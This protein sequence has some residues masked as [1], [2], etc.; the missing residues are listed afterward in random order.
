MHEG[1][2]RVAHG[3]LH[4]II[5]DSL[6]LEVSRGIVP[7]LELES[8][9]LLAEVQGVESREERHLEVH[10]QQIVEILLVRGGERVHREVAARPRVHIGVQT[11]LNHVEKGVSHGVLGGATG[12]QV[13]QNMGFSRV[14]I[15]RGPK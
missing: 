10:R 1:I 6:V 9:P 2:L 12:C 14:V 8:V 3:S 7:L 13:L 5:H 15:R 11:S 4:L